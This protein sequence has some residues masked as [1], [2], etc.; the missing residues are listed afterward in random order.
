MTLSSAFTIINSAFDSNAA[1]TAAVSRNITNANKT[2]YTIKT[3]NLGTTSYG[4]AEVTSITRATNTALL[5]QMLA[6]NSQAA[7]QSA[8]ATGLTQLSATVSDNSSSASSDT[9]T[10]ASGQ[11]PAALLAS[12]QSALQNYESTPS[13]ETVAQ[14]VVSAA[15]SLT[16]SLH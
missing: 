2:G 10:T 16:T 14:S 8:L 6:A 1:Q 4:G 11:S 7:Q 3:A 15:S 12:L 9:A 13:N 5:D